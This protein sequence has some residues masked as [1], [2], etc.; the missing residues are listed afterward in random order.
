MRWDYLL[1]L[2]ALALAGCRGPSAATGAASKTA[3][4][5]EDKKPALIVNPATGIHGRII[6]V[7]PSTRY[8]IIRYPFG[9][10]PAVDRKFNVYRNGLKVAEIKIN[11]FRRDTNIVA[12]I[13]VGECQVGDE[14]R[15]D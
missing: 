13:V 1:L 7:N 5:P 4:I 10:I 14:V 12:D 15:E 9:N 2:G 8:V 3:P 11:D 6:R